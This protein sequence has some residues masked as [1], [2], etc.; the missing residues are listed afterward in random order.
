[1]RAWERV[2]NRRHRIGQMQFRHLPAPRCGIDGSTFVIAE[3]S[4]NPPSHFVFK[5]NTVRISESR[6]GRREIK[7]W[8]FASDE[9]IC[10]YF[11]SFYLLV[12]RL[13]V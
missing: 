4:G 10:S 11:F 9:D 2:I 13:E 8:A 6:K 5:S 12:F 7:K 1:M 3:V